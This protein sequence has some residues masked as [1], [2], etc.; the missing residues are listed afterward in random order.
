MTKL[1]GRKCYYFPNP[2]TKTFDQYDAAISREEEQ[3]NSDAC[4]S[5]RYNRYLLHVHLP[6]MCH[7]EQLTGA[8]LRDGGRVMDQS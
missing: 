5:R 2:E 7:R 3:L 6:F 1:V 8:V 4:T